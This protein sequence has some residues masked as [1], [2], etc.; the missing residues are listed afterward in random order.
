LLYLDFFD[1][2]RMYISNN[3][4]RSTFKLYMKYL[5]K[6]NS[7]EC[8]EKAAA[9]NVLIEVLTDFCAVKGFHIKDF[10]R[11]LLFSTA[12]HIKTFHIHT[13]NFISI[14]LIYILWILMCFGGVKLIRVWQLWIQQWTEIFWVKSRGSL[15]HIIASMGKTLILK[16]YC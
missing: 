15:G 10:I 12:I 16:C 9:V 3:F 5:V 13:H 6:E 1:K 7:V 11:Q 4:Y 2:C 8:R 14:H